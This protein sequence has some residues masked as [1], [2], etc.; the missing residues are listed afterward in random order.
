[1]RY[2]LNRR[3]AVRLVNEVSDR[4]GF[5]A[6][7][8]YFTK[9]LATSAH[10]RFGRDVKME[11]LSLPRAEFVSAYLVSH[12]LAHRGNHVVTHKRDFDSYRKE[13]SHGRGFVNWLDRVNAVTLVVLVEWFGKDPETE[14][15]E[16]KADPVQ[17]V[18][19][20]YV[21]GVLQ[22]S[23]LDEIRVEAAHDRARALR[24]QRAGGAN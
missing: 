7:P 1:M 22:L 9:K 11:R 5:E 20:S 6:P 3:E 14:Q 17:I 23:L 24:A 19:R 2:T 10:Y 16:P 13:Q 18:K 21:G 8:V 4:M 12:E 15:P